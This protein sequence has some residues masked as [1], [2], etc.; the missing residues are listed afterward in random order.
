MASW[1]R[2]GKQPPL[3]VLE[4]VEDR[5]R[6]LKRPAYL[7]ELALYV[8]WSLERAEEMMTVLCE[9]G[10]AKKLDAVELDRGCF[11][12]GANVYTF[13]SSSFS[14]AHLPLGD[15]DE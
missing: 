1:L 5:L 10:V 11:P 3:R 4:R 9:K 14:C 8:C 15:F 13:L 6:D 7:G 2:E 12:E